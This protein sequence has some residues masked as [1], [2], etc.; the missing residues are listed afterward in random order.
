MT[1][2]EISGKLRNVIE[3]LVI[4]TP[5]NTITAKNIIIGETVRSDYFAFNTLREARD[6]F[7][8]DFIHE[9]A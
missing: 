3:R 8:K 1:G 5:S 4:M 6:S 2:P 7:E 9:K